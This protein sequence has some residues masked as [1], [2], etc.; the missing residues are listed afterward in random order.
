M[1]RPMGMMFVL[2][3]ASARAHGQAASQLMELPP[4]VPVTEPH[5]AAVTAGP[6]YGQPFSAI[7]TRDTYRLLGD[8]TKIEHHTAV[9]VRRDSAGR[10]RNDTTPEPLPGNKDAGTRIDTVVYDGELE[11]R[12][13]NL[14]RLA[15]MRHLP[16]HAPT[17]PPAQPKELLPGETRTVWIGPAGQKQKME[18][19]VLPG[20]TLEGMETRGSRVV[21][22]VPSGKEGNDRDLVT[23]IDSWYQPEL[24]LAMWTETTDPAM[25]HTTMKF[26]SLR[27]ENQP[28]ELFA[29]PPGYTVR[30][31]S[32]VTAAR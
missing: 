8:G 10:M 7:R 22:F 9:L 30:E 13:N 29:P 5:Q 25:G 26:T 31:I 1:Y 21:K 3:T 17:A 11:I 23:T 18:A 20:R 12:W 2:L 32:A 14:S 24:H 6:V 27:R 16:Q 4:S 19:S 15:T 28:E